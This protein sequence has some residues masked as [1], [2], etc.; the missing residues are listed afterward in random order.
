MSEGIL[1][2]TILGRTGDLENGHHEQMTEHEEVKL[3]SERSFGMTFAVVFTL[4]ALWL[5]WR[6]DVP[7]WALFFLASAIV[8][9]ILAYQS[10]LVL[11]PLNRVWMKFGLLLH[12]IINPL[13]IGDLSRVHPDRHHHAATGEGFAPT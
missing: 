10:P 1:T 5:Y 13:V 3:P 12:R 8:F 6:K 4:L 2:V 7:V 9:A 11:R